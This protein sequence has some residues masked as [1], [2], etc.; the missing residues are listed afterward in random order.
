MAVYIV[1]GVVGAWAGYWIGHALGWSTNATWPW[2]FGGGTGAILLAFG[3]SVL[4]VVVAALLLAFLSGRNVRKAL[5]NGV[6]ARAS[7]LSIEKTGDK[8][9][10]PEGKYNQVRCELEV[11]PRDGE[12][13]RARITQFLTEGYLQGLEPGS[14]VHVRYDPAQRT[15]V[16]IIEHSP[17]RK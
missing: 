5:E 10:T 7:V 4:F 8:T 16:A 2:S 6:P 9:T 1:S 3:M 17:R 15:H 12:R 13:Y 11:R 14:M